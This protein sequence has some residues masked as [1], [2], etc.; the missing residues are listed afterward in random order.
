MRPRLLSVITPAVAWLVVSTTPARAQSAPRFHL[1]AGPLI[2][3]PRVPL[4]GPVL[5]VLGSPLRTHVFTPSAT[6]QAILPECRMPVMVPDLSK[7]ER[8]PGS[9]APGAASIGTE[10]F[11]CTNPLGPRA[12][13]PVP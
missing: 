4:S 7:S 2:A 5:G 8:M 12:R 10:R 1:S 9:H 3:Q 13:Q 11:G 6:L